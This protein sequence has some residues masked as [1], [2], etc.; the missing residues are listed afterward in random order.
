MPCTS[1]SIVPYSSQI[2]SA[3]IDWALVQLLIEVNSVN[4][5]NKVRVRDITYIPI[6]E[7]RFGYLAIL[8]IDFRCVL[9]DGISAMI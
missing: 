7:I 5:T 1:N 3:A 2:V 6:T 8:G 9:M 4:D